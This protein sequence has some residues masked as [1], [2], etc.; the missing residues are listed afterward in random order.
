MIFNMPDNIT[1][2]TVVG[3]DSAIVTWTE[4]SGTDNSGIQ[5]LTSSHSPP[6]KF[7]LGRS[8]VQYSSTDLAGN[9]VTKEMHVLVTY[10][11]KSNQITGEMIK[12][13]YHL[14]IQILSP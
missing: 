5:T 4:P 9:R 6:F 3:N 14:T 1:V 10:R 13:F 8:V 7:P 12:Y 11:K 2:Y